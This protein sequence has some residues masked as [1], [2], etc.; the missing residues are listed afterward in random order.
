MARPEF[1]DMVATYD[2]RL[3]NVM[4]GLTGDYHDALDLTEE[5]FIRAMKAYPRFRGDS[6]PF[7]WLY[8][9]ALNVLKKRYRKNARRAELWQEHQERE[10]AQ[11][12]ETRTAEHSVLQ[13][14]RAHLVRQA[15]AQL[16]V[17]FREVITLRYIDE[18][19]YEEIAESAGCSM[20]TV[21]SRISRGKALLADLLGG[22]V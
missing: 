4:Y 20:G 5:A 19:S 21:K 15:I 10:P 6:D 22:K 7:T 8:R 17:A 9:I 3:F 11:V 18:M 14:E 2:K 13:E 12:S 16:P 1:E